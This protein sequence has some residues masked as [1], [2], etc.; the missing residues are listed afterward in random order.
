MLFAIKTLTDC[1]TNFIKVINLNAD[2]PVGAEG[3]T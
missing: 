2:H 3:S 1:F